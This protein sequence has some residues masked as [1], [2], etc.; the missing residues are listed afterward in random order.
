MHTQEPLR[1]HTSRASMR[2]GIHSRWL[3]LY[4]KTQTIPAGKEIRSPFLDVTRRGDFQ[5]GATVFSRNCLPR[6]ILMQWNVSH[7]L[8]VSPSMLEEESSRS[9]S[10]WLSCYHTERPTRLGVTWAIIQ[11]PFWECQPCLVLHWLHMAWSL[12]LSVN[13]LQR[14]LWSP[15]QVCHCGRTNSADRQTTG[16]WD[17]L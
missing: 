2:W 12:S 4:C 7:R 5:A 14:L 15:W 9:L 6:F 10:S 8:C 16:A 3:E 13:T 17:S 1:R 11:L